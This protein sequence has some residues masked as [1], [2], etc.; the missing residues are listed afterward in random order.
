MI[1]TSALI[2]EAEATRENTGTLRKIASNVYLV[3]VPITIIATWL[4]TDVF[5]K[6]WPTY[7]YLKPVA[8]ILVICYHIWQFIQERRKES[9]EASTTGSRLN[10]IEVTRKEVENKS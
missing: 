10:P 5:E 3:A 6:I 4:V 1:Q 8:V 7:G 9:R 2:V